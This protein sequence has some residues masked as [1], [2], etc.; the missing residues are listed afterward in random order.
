M[1]QLVHPLKRQ[2]P[3]FF[4]RFYYQPIPRFYRVILSLCAISLVAA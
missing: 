1:F 2:I 4:E 3:T